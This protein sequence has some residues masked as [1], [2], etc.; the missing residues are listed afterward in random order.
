MPAD[1]G[2]RI[3]R[4]GGLGRVLA[5]SVLD[6]NSVPR[7]WDHVTK[8]DPEEAKKLPLLFPLWLRHTDA[9]SVGGSADVNAGNTETTFDLLAPLSTPICH[10]PSGARHVTNS[11]RERAELLLIP[12]VLNGESEALV[13]ELGAAVEYVREEMAPELVARKARWLPDPLADRV[14]DV[15][16][17][18]MLSDAAFEA[19]IVQNPDSAAARESG[20]DDDDVLSPGEAKRRAMAADRHLA[21]EIVYLE[22]SGRYGGP[23]ALE[24]L[25]QF[26]D[27]LT[28]ARVWYGGGLANGEDVRDVLDAGADTVVVGDA[29]HRVADEEATLLREAERTL[30]ADASAA[31]LREWIR[32]RVD[33][34]G[35]G[36][37]YLSTVP[38]VNDPTGLARTYARQTV[39]AWL[40]LRARGAQDRDGRRPLVDLQRTTFRAALDPVLGDDGDG[41]AA[42]LASAALEGR[43]SG[44]AASGEAAHLSTSL[45]EE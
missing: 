16:T 18:Y 36:A 8:V 7:E 14:A 40:D 19:Y 41:Y 44:P 31:T 32:D 43:S 17:S 37:R 24:T 15:A 25:R 39:E 3:G 10:E 23:E 6:T 12:E 42:T 1:I 2:A 11:T 45:V 35:A 5:R 22:Y 13:G 30:A 38:G 28:R 9:V 27:A 21:S 29:F 20:V 26:D 4:L 34:D 33:G